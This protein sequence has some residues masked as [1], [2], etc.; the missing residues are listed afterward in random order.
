MNLGP[1]LSLAMIVL[2]FVWNV[3]LWQQKRHWREQCRLFESVYGTGRKDR[4]RTTILVRPTFSPYRLA[5]VKSDVRIWANKDGWVEIGFSHPI[6]NSFAL[7]PE[8]VAAMKTV[9]DSVAP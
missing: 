3:I 9:A 2:L 1:F 5:P 7:S 6:V 8:T 4:I